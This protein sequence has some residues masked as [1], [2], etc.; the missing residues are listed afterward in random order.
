MTFN[1]C[2][3]ILAYEKTRF[4]DEETE[5]IKSNSCGFVHHSRSLYIQSIRDTDLV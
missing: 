5:T 2:N 4:R 3:S 1:G